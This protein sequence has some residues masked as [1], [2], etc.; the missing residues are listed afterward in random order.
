MHEPNTFP[1]I[2]LPVLT[3][4]VKVSTW[5]AANEIFLESPLLF[6]LEI[7]AVMMK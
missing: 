4:F 5:E 2:R 3:N 7:R 1:A 6:P